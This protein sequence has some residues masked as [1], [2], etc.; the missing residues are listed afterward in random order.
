MGRLRAQQSPSCLCSSER[1]KCLLIGSADFRS[2]YVW[3]PSDRKTQDVALAE[4]EYSQVSC[5]FSQSEDLCK[6]AVGAS[7]TRGSELLDN[8]S[9]GLMA[10]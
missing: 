5:F 8:L 1:V 3:H 10:W 2:I 4:K 7:S 9:E 6:E